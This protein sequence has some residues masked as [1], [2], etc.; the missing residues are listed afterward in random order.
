MIREAARKALFAI[1]WVTRGWYER[2]GQLAAEQA[3]HAATVDAAAS[4]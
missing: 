1:G 2:S 4:H 3:Q